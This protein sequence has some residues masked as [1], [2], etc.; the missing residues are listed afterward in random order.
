MIAKKCS[1][2]RQL[3]KTMLDQRFLR[4]SKVLNIYGAVVDGLDSTGIGEELL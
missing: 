4:C 3:A 1:C 2:S